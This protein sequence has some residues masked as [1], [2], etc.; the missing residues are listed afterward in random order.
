MTGARAPK[1]NRACL[2]SFEHDDVGGVLDLPQRRVGRHEARLHPLF[3]SLIG[4]AR[5]AEEL[6]AKPHV[7]CLVNVVGGD[8]RD[9]LDPDVAEIDAR[10]VGDGRDKRELVRS[11]DSADIE[12][13]VGF[14]ISEI[15]CLL[16]YLFVAQP[17][18]FHPRQDVVAG[19]VHYAHHA[20]DLVRRHAFGQSF[21]DGYSA[22]DGGF[23]AQ[24]AT[25][26]F[27]GFSEFLAMEC[28]QR[29]VGCNDVLAGCDRGFNGGF[30]GVSVS[31]HQFNENVYVRPHRQ[32]DRVGRPIEFRNIDVPFPIP[33]AGAY[34]LDFDSAAYAAREE[35]F[36]LRDDFQD[37]GAHRSESCDSKSDRFGQKSDPLSA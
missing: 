21:D 25:G 12:I 36:V 2:V 6:D 7:S 26:P 22:G 8:S 5:D 18:S 35:H 32:I 29:L 30:S 17:R 10:S 1:E 27:R 34:G 16:E 31:P 19:A 37:A 28:K 4:H 15:A 23:E 24:N 11:V 13:R 3:K 33:V 14:Q 9:A 20:R